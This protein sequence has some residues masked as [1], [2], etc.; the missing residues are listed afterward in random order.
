MKVVGWFEC[1]WFSLIP[2]VGFL[3]NGDGVW[4]RLGARWCG[5]LLSLL[6]YGCY[7]KKGIVD[8][9]KVR[10]Q[11]W[12]G[13]SKWSNF[14]LRLGSI[15]VQLFLYSL[16]SW[17]YFNNNVIITFFDFVKFHL[18]IKK[19]DWRMLLHTIGWFCRNIVSTVN[20]ECKLDLKAIALQARNAE[21][22]P[23]V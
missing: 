22:N 4:V 5:I 18:Y 23:K 19:C 20:L 13:L 6:F 1:A 9:S 2:S 21:Y 17:K 11:L 16:M 10:L 12:T 15:T 14:W 8:V 7:R 3:K